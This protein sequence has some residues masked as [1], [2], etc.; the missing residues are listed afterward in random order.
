MSKL[1][2]LIPSRDRPKH[3]INLLREIYVQT[4]LP[5]EVVICDQSV[6]SLSE[7]IAKKFSDQAKPKVLY[8]HEPE[9]NGLVEARKYCVENMSCKSNY[10][11]FFD[12]DIHISDTFI[13]NILQ[14]M[15]D[16]YVA[17]VGNFS[18]V[19]AK[20]GSTLSARLRSLFYL[21][22]FYDNRWN[23]HAD[24]LSVA[25]GGLVLWRAEHLRQHIYKV[26]NALFYFEDIVTS[27][28]LVQATNLKIK[29]SKK[30]IASDL[31]LN[32][33]VHN[34]YETAC[35]REIDL[36]GR[37]F[38]GDVLWFHL[39]IIKLYFRLARLKRTLLS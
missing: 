19:T 20:L 39:N 12:D 8:Y 3:L 36:I 16:E 4:H 10:C 14:D 1:S 24:I 32:E 28:I 27:R 38:D 17:V 21:G 22:F 25:S 13:E 15:S 23:K 30:A 5:D 31:Q 26:P 6:A 9:I 37:I 33:R 7:I 34:S 11:L 2:I 18:P 29:R 35:I